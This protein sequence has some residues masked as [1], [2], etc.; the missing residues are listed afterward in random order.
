MS[1]KLSHL[2]LHVETVQT[3]PVEGPWPSVA[4]YRSPVDHPHGCSHK[5]FGALR[6]SETQKQL[7]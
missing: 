3:P 1:L 2:C 4:V 5:C 6:L 7:A